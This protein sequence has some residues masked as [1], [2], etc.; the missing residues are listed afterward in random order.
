MTPL[1]TIVDH[2]FH[3]PNCHNRRSEVDL[4]V[5]HKIAIPLKNPD[6]QSVI[7]FFCNELQSDGSNYL[8]S[9][10]GLKVSAHFVIAQDGTIAQFLCPWTQVAWHCGQSF[11]QGRTKCN[12]FS[13]GI[14][15]IGFD[16]IDLT[17]AQ[18]QRGQSLLRYL[19]S[20]FALGPSAVV[21]H[22]DIAPGR[23]TDPGFVNRERL[24]ALVSNGPLILEEQF[25]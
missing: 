25:H 13:I 17:V 24:L 5:L 3:S 15:F 20:A 7:D 21:G 22:C 12:E 9:L 23:K 2:R 14:E 6:L 8:N 4:I 19:Y 16:Q 11:Y 10:E 18:Y 1:N